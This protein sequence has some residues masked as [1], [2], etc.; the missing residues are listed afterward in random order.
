[1]CIIHCSRSQRM[2]LVMELCDA[3]GLHQLLEKKGRF[4]EKVCLVFI[5]WIQYNEQ[6]ANDFTGGGCVCINTCLHTLVLL[7][8]VYFCVGVWLGYYYFLYRRFYCF[9]AILCNGGSQMFN[10]KLS[11]LKAWIYNRGD[12]VKSSRKWD[13]TDSSRCINRSAS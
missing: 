5:V 4:T 6:V 12:F 3:G 13:M 7:V 9:I 11:S 10:L 1:M 8:I 2:Y